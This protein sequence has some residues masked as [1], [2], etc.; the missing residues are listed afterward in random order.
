MTIVPVM[1]GMRALRRAVRRTI[2]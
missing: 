1:L 2:M